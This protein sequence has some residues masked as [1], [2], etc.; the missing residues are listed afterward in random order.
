MANSEGW[1]R[2][3]RGRGSG[4]NP[5]LTTATVTLIGNHGFISAY[6]VRHTLFISC[7]VFVIAP[8]H[9]QHVTLD[10]SFAYRGNNI[11]MVISEKVTFAQEVTQNFGKQRLK[12]QT[13]HGESASLQSCCGRSFIRHFHSSVIRCNGIYPPQLHTDR[14]KVGLERVQGAV[15]RKGVI[16]NT[17]KKPQTLSS[18]QRDYFLSNYLSSRWSKYCTADKGTRQRKDGKTLHVSSEGRVAAI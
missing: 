15:G 2:R 11:C 10:S 4:T 5:P 8:V 9:Q 18:P 12:W 7:F 16:W 6:S 14:L 1:R 13:T 17:R 3:N